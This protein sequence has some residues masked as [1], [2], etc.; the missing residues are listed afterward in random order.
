M[1]KSQQLH[2][3]P[4]KCRKGKKII[5]ASCRTFSSRSSEDM[6]PV[7]EALGS[8]R[9]PWASERR[10]ISN[11]FTIPRWDS[12][13]M[14]QEIFSTWTGQWFKTSSC[15]VSVT[16][17]RPS[18]TS[19]NSMKMFRFTSAG[20][21]IYKKVYDRNQTYG[22]LLNCCCVSDHL[23]AHKNLVGNSEQCFVYADLFVGICEIERGKQ[24]CDGYTEIQLKW[25]GRIWS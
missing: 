10:D 8:L 12:N 1:K 24:M 11:S 4:L 14:L 6:V 22:H 5:P 23:V 25:C 17:A 21:V 3:L 16:V 19:I 7:E 13:K 2:C 18:C 9:L 20:R 15:A